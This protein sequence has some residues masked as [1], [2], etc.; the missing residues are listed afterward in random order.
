MTGLKTDFTV[1]EQV[2][3][4]AGLSLFIGRTGTVVQVKRNLIDV[5][6]D[7]SPGSDRQYLFFPGELV[8]RRC[9]TARLLHG[10]DCVVLRGH[11]GPRAP[12]A[13]LFRHLLRTPL[14]AYV[15]NVGGDAESRDV[16][17]S[18]VAA[19]LSSCGF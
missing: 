13:K 6:L 1:G 8:A 12:R 4:V 10:R 15:S 5:L 16:S 9:Y 7:N 11:V 19:T 14:G 17:A 18:A 2:C 3:I